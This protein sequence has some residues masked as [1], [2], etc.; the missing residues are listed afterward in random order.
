MAESGKRQIATFNNRVTEIVPE[1]RQIQPDKG[2]ITVTKE[3]VED[4]AYAPFSS[5]I[6]EEGM[7]I[8]DHT[9]ADGRDDYAD[10]QLVAIVD[11]S[12]R[13]LVPTGEDS[14]SPTYERKLSSEGCVI[15]NNNNKTVEKGQTYSFTL[16]PAQGYAKVP[17][18]HIEVQT[19]INTWETLTS[20]NWERSDSVQRD[21]NSVSG[22]I[23][24]VFDE[25][26]VYQLTIQ[27]TLDG[28]PDGQPTIQYKTCED[29]INIDSLHPA[30]TGKTFV[31]V[32]K[33]TISGQ[34]V[35]GVQTFCGNT[36]LY[37][38]Y[39]TNGYTVN[40]DNVATECVNVS[41]SRNLPIPHGS[42]LTITLTPKSGKANLGAGSVT[43]GNQAIDSWAAGE[44]DR[45][46]TINSVTD[47]IVVSCACGDDIITTYDVDLQWYDPDIPQM[48]GSITL[49]DVLS[50]ESVLAADHANDFTLPAGYTITAMSPSE[51]TVDSSSKV[52]TYTCKK[53]QYTV[54]YNGVNVTLGKQSETVSHGEDS[55]NTYTI[56]PGY[57]GV[58][59][60]ANDPSKVG[61]ITA[62]NGQITVTNITGNV[63]ITV[64]SG[65]NS[66]TVTYTGDTNANIPSGTTQTVV[67]GGNAANYTVPV[68]SGYRIAG[69]SADD[70]TKATVGYS[71]DVVSVTNVTGNVTINI[72]TD[73]IPAIVYNVTLI[74][75][76]NSIISGNSTVN[77]GTPYQF[78]VTTAPNYTL[79]DL[80]I[81][82]TS[83]PTQTTK[84]EDIPNVTIVKNDNVTTVTIPLISEDVTIQSTSMTTDTTFDVTPVLYTVSGTFIG[85]KQYDV[86]SAGT[87]TQEII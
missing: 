31:K 75:D 4:G 40:T 49:E 77:S 11:L 32:T 80:V 24:I 14:T 51:I 59:A 64:S 36:T 61:Q 52:I 83:D 67:H 68:S 39:E 69:V 7:F 66:Y 81:Y 3:S 5:D 46:V 85:N 37:I 50:T 13:F 17:K 45:S 58:T 82:P 43:M 54:T 2:T 19:G 18:G 76:A 34:E 10:N 42:S 63:T 72:T 9:I 47:D 87:W 6:S 78:T 25:E 44:S 65:L 70:P 23:K 55:T 29:E 1:Y 84:V 62:T 73:A 71:G 38:N 48:L 12:Y 79:Y 20:Y 22:N 28:N 8:V 56:D 60:V 57:S 74:G 35:S 26:C 15:T 33:D 21:I 27:N 30:Q 53:N 86:T 41:Y 16:T